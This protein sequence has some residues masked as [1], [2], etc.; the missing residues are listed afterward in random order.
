MVHEPMSPVTIHYILAVA[1]AAASVGCALHYQPPAAD[2]PHALVKVRRV[3]LDRPGPNVREEVTLNGEIVVARNVGSEFVQAPAIQAVRVHP[4][5][6]QWRASSHFYHTVTTTERRPHT[7]TERY[8]CGTSSVGGRSQTR[9]CTRSK[10]EYR[11]ETVTRQV[12]DGSCER[13]ASL[14]PRVGGVYLL[15]YSFT[16][17]DVCS[18]LCMEQHPR[19]DGTFDSL[20]CPPAPTRGAD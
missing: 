5:P 4:A 15:S 3:Y 7:V 6:I 10:T 13:V 11:T 14:Q 16:G 20:P 8:A 9:Y 19:G 2:E 12:S 17:P 1:I 18:L